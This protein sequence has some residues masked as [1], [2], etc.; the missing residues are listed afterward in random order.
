MALVE[1]SLA[2]ET[3]TYEMYS[4]IPQLVVNAMAIAKQNRPTYKTKKTC[5]AYFGGKGALTV[6]VQYST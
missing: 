5:M 1:N 6:L 3:F 2:G 4:G